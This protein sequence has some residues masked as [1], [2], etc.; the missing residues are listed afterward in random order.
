MRTE[1]QLKQLE[2]ARTHIKNRTCTEETKRK[3]SV[4]NDGN[5][6]GVCDYCGKKY[7]T[8]KSH[9][10]R[11]K[12]HFC[13]RSCYSKY[14]EELLPK[15]EQNAYGTGF[16]QQER[17]KRKKARSILNHYLRDN[18]IHRQPCEICGNKKAE[19]HHDD[20]DKPLEIR[21]LCFN[22]HRQWHKK[23]NNPELLKGGGEE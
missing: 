23:H 12:R 9:Y 10:E 15:E 11:H 4:A 14:R 13:S 7:H 5:F 20:Y 2:E 3:I 1:K 19:A 21:W 16:S 18:N 22:C 6:F 17:D 8:K